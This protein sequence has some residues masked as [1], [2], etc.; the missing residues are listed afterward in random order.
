MIFFVSFFCV[1]FAL[2]AIRLIEVLTNIYRV[3]D[4]IRREIKKQG[5][6]DTSNI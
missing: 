1:S 3:L 5:N 6:G 4:D 2:L